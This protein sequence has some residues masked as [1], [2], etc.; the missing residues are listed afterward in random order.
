MGSRGLFAGV[1][2][3]AALAAAPATADKR[4]DTLRFAYDQSVE[5]I[6]PYF[7]NVRLGVI[8]R[9][10][11]WDTLI[12][13][14]PASGE[15]KPHLATAW[16]TIDDKTLEFDLRRGVKFHDG[17]EF[18]ADDVVYTLNFVSNPA[19]KA[20]TQQYVS[21][22]DHAEK[23]DPY[24]VRIVTKQPTPSAIEYLSSPIVIHP[25]EH[26]AK[27]GPKLMNEKPVGS[28]PYRV[29]QHVLG[30][31]ILL[32]RNPD[33]FGPPA[34]I[35]KVE[36][37]IIPDRQTQMAE[38][39]SG[40]LDLIMH[41]PT[42]QAE[43]LKTV[44]N[45]QV[46]GGETMRIAFL[47]LNTL[48]DTPAPM[49]KDVRVRRAINHAI[50]R[51]TMMSRI[52]GE[53]ARVIDTVCFPTQFGCTEEGAARYDYDPP[54][55]KQLLAEAGFPN[56]FTIPFLAYR[57][58]NQSEAVIGYLRAVGITANLSFMQYA[59][60]RDQVRAHRSGIAHWTW[61]SSSINDVSASTPIYFKFSED[62]VNRD[63]QVRAALDEGDGVM[64][65]ERRKAAYKRALTRIADQAYAV[66]LYSLPVAYVGAKDLAFKAYP[67]EIPRFF[68]MS[69]K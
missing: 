50:D 37:R 69:W 60:M 31:T 66:P 8:L 17:Q 58:R 47:Q 7:N 28:G 38:M 6:D 59:A 62:D 67:D 25:H 22:I 42:D 45:L 49:L 44:P 55:A 20:V 65:P 57:E 48:D 5:N 39:L 1:V 16:R 68:E 26:Y 36:I 27:G 32:E 63:E 35:G 19:N 34:K 15:Y 10:Q 2:V 13:R 21:W 64:D 43:Q 56:G 29:V 23:L 24:K 52:V 46:V 53:G 40:G 61:G 4:S 9:H 54:K 12:S 14:D 30:K 51:K 33:Y 3:L 18:T 41:V 11:I